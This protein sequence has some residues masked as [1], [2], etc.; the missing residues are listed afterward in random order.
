MISFVALES[1]TG[2]APRKARG[3]LK[4]NLKIKERERGRERDGSSWKRSVIPHVIDWPRVLELYYQVHLE[5][6]RSGQYEALLQQWVA[7]G[8]TLHLNGSD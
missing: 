4:I 7:E 5:V 2:P 8:G 3:I 6:D 1:I